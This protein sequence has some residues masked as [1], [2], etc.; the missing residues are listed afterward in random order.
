MNVMGKPLSRA[1]KTF[2]G[3]GDLGF[4]L[5]SA[6]ELFLFVFFLTTV[7]KFSLPVVALI[8][9]VTAI[10]DT[11]LSPFYGAII[12]GTKALKW[13]RNRSWLLVTPPIVVVLFMFQF[14]KIGTD[15]VAAII[16]CA[17]F[18]LSHIVWNMG[19]VANVSLI[20][21]MANNP[22]ERGLLASRRGAW[23]GLGTVFFSYIGAP[24]ALFLGAVT[25]HPILGYTL[26]AGI[27]GL[28]FLSGYWTVFTITDGY[29]PTGEE[30]QSAAEGAK[31]SENVSGS[32]M[33]KSV[34]Q[35]SPLLLLLLGDFFRWMVFFIMT[36]AAAFYFTYVAQN[37]KLFPIYLL[38]GGIAQVIGSY[39]SG[40]ISKALSTRTATIIGLFGLAA[41]LIL[42]K[43]A[44][45]NVLLFFVVVIPAN[46]FLGVLAAVMV[47]LYA[48]VVVYGEW[49]TGKN[50]ASFI[51]GLMNV[52][53]K[54]AVISRGTI[55]PLVLAA[56]GFAERTDPTA[57]SLVMKTAVINVF[58]LI[59]GIFA[60]VGA[61]IITFGY[62]LTREKVVTYQAEIDKRKAQTV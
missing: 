53:L 1:I 50:A 49:K 51:M 14:T 55:I 37:M 52:S 7:A 46:F 47:A 4:T 15:S 54:A 39:F 35:N 2:Y 45:M 48:D 9:S 33:L 38:L 17:G 13:G 42:C 28:T 56:A 57:V 44:G 32:V 22:E 12:N 43:Y 21:V 18:I 60:L 10:V 6:V 30:T 59:P 34:F 11:V 29:E 20:A 5:M 61:L 58:V 41:S 3:I 19:W 24:F 31:K 25:G 40:N 23:T 27:L 8:G 36:A 16:V 26:L 62:R